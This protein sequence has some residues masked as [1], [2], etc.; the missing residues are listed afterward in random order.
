MTYGLAFRIGVVALAAIIGVTLPGDALAS[1]AAETG[2]SAMLYL[3]ELL[4]GG[5]VLGA[6]LLLDT[7]TWP[8]LTSRR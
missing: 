8:V 3:D 1:M 7:A 2:S 5:A 4:I 6:C